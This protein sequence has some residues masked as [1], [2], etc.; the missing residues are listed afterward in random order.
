MFGEFCDYPYENIGFDTPWV[1]GGALVYFITKEQNRNC[2]ICFIRLYIYDVMCFYILIHIVY[3]NIYIIGYGS[4][5]MFMQF[6]CSIEP[7]KE[8]L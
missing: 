1:E 4:L 6:L 5:C 7:K 3:M 8:H 2:L